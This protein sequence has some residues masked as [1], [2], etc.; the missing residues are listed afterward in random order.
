M[1][2]KT[3]VISINASWNVVN[4]RAGLVRALRGA[5]FD[6]VALAPSDDYSPRLA[7]L[8]ARHWP[9]EMDR[10][11]TSPLRDALLAARYYQALRRIRPDVYLGYTA[12]PNIY[13]SLAAH[14][15]GIPVINN[16]AGLG[17][18]FL[19]RDWLNFIVRSLYR[20]AFRR[21]KHVFFQNPDDLAL[22]S[23]A[24]LVDAVK[25]SLLPGSGVDLERFKPR[26]RVGGGASGF[27]FLLV[28][29][30]LWSKGIG[31]YVRAAEGLR[32]SHPQARFAIAGIIDGDRADA[33]SRADVRKWEES[34]LIDYL[35]ALGDVRPALAAADCVVLPSYYP[36]GTPRSLL[37]AAAMG[38]PIITC[39]VPGC[40]EIV[41]DQVNGFLC[42]PRDPESLAGAMERMIDMAPDDRLRMG[43]AS[44]REAET[45]FDERIVI[46]RYLQQIAKVVAVSRPTGG[47]R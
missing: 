41:R 35:G 32:A 9:V 18:T 46:D 27:T 1:G 24:D 13:G 10:R 47:G 31:E 21:S 19:K 45:R 20:L 40:R 2:N 26:L 29:R 39:D 3:A 36:E 37:E 4:F 15:L 33:V 14:A 25:I 16:V 11:G 7:E 23:D 22:F 8:G 42:A 12:K 38:K 34:G 30:L 5:G 44:R 28:S 6:V 43:N 17:V